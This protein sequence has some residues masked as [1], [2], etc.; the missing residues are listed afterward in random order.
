MGGYLSAD[1]LYEGGKYERKNK[2][3]TKHSYGSCYGD[4]HNYHT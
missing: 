3:T 1:I 2:K 4:I